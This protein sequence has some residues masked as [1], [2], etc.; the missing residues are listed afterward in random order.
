MSFMAPGTTRQSSSRTEARSCGRYSSNTG[1]VRRSNVLRDGLR[2]RSGAGG[3]RTGCLQL[4]SGRDHRRLNRSRGPAESSASPVAAHCAGRC[5]ALRAGRRA[6]ARL[7]PRRPST[8]PQRHPRAALRAV[9]VVLERPLHR[10][11][12]SDA[13][14]PARHRGRRAAGCR[15]PRE[16]R[17]S[18]ARLLPVPR[19][20]SLAIS[21]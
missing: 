20:S 2:N 13:V 4:T 9:P 3:D 5:A 6:A 7:E 16:R 10:W 11:Q 8:G 21:R 19:P 14:C 17:P 18:R 15:D 12:L 1:T